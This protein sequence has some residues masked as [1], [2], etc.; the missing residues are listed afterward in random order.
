MFVQVGYREKVAEKVEDP[1]EDWVVVPC[2]P[3]K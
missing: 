1:V 2:L 3:G